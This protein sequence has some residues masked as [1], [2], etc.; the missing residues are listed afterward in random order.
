MKRQA[1]DRP[2]AETTRSI[3]FR[4]PLAA[5]LLLAGW[6]ATPASA[7][8]AFGPPE[9]GG[10]SLQEE[11]G[12][13]GERRSLKPIIDRAG[14]PSSPART[15]F[16]R[17][18]IYRRTLANTVWL[19]TPSGNT[20]SGWVYDAKLRLVVTNHHVVG[21]HS[22]VKAYFPDFKDGRPVTSR[23]HYRSNVTPI[24]AKVLKTDSFRDLALVQL[25]RLPSSAAGIK[26]AAQ[27]AESAD[28]LHVVGGNTQESSAMWGYVSGTVRVVSRGGGFLKCWV[29]ENQVPTNKGNSGGPAVNDYGELVAVVCRTALKADTTKFFVDL[30]EVRTFLGEAERLGNP[31]TDDDY[32]RLGVVHFAGSRYR[33]AIDAFTES[34]RRDDDDV[35]TIVNRAH[36]YLVTGDHRTALADLNEAIR[37]DPKS[38]RAY[39]YRS[40]AHQK[41]KKYQQGV[42][43]AAVAIRL[44]PKYAAAYYSRGLNLQLQ[45]K[46]SEAL[47]DYNRALEIE[48]K[49]SLYVKARGDLLFE[50]GNYPQCA[51]DLL[52]AVTLGA[53]SF[54]ILNT[55]GRSL[56]RMKDYKKAVIAYTA[57]VKKDPKQPSGHVNLALAYEKLNRHDDAAKH[58]LEAA[59]LRPTTARYYAYLGD[60]LFKMNKRKE[61]VG[62]YTL[63]LKHDSDNANYYYTRSLLRKS[64]GDSAGGDADASKANQLDPKGYPREHRR[65]LVVENTS[66]DPITVYVRYYTKTTSGNWKWFPAAPGVGQP[67]GFYLNP[68][69]KVN[70]YDGDFRVRA[71]KVRVWASSRT[72]DWHW[73]KHRDT[74]LYL[75]P[76]GGYVK[77][78][79]SSMG[80]FT[81]TFF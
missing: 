17:K 23:D 28:M 64:L 2:T 56:Y 80:A 77:K 74:D 53:E 46:N 33:A 68:G 34:L 22:E 66:K 47:A 61:A 79:G 76:K 72:R 69:Q 67:K 55:L 65:Y 21:R 49:N 71:Y 42:D 18:Q 24:S 1:N 45:E 9:S 43:D 6:Q 35:T 19:V 73:N 12:R 50:M 8:D 78:S 51:K 11:E 60:S 3:L 70:V 15:P 16:T 30:R 39:R 75:A 4:L 32:N 10:P 26:L 38:A 37:I 20:G 57:A 31:Q 44:N 52:K 7:D 63:A 5:A 62:A 54:D 27:S 14:S 29:V 58:Y 40:W 25:D 36:A 13:S 59:K 81:W 41:V 48:P